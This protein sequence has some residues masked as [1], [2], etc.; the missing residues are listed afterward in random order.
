MFARIDM[1][2][3]VATL[4]LQAFV[5]G[6]LMKRLGVPLTLALLP[7]HRRAGIHRPCHCRFDRGAHRVR[8][9]VPRGAARHH[10][11]CARDALYRRSARRALQVEGGY[12]HVRLSGGGSSLAR[13]PRACLSSWAWDWRRSAP[14]LCRSPR[15]G[16]RSG[17]GSATRSAGGRRYASQ[18][19]LAEAT[20]AWQ[21]VANDFSAQ[22][23]PAGSW[24]SIPA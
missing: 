9:D 15:R 16:W 5:T 22:R 14:S 8:G 1:I 24:P 21:R 17:F 19:S 7:A 3:Q 18:L 11:A 12:R 20:P 10:A 6:H 13:R 23:V 2:T 4:V